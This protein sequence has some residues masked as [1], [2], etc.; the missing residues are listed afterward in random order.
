[1]RFITSQCSSLNLCCT[2]QSDFNGPFR[3][4]ASAATTS[5][6]NELRWPADISSPLRSGRPFS[7]SFH[8]PPVRSCID[9]TKLT[10]PKPYSRSVSM[11]SILSYHTPN[12][13]RS[14]EFAEG[15]DALEKFIASSRL[16]PN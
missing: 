9:L 13:G 6:L 14:P 1:M 4:A 11:D 8:R 3:L 7:G 5:T 10:G 15:G 2:N 16:P 12:S